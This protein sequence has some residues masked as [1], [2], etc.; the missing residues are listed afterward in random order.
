MW[1]STFKLSDISRRRI[2][3][4]VVVLGAAAGGGVPQ[5]NC[6]CP[7]CRTA[8]TDPEH[9]STQASI[10]ISAHDAHWYLINASPDLR[11]QLIPTPKLHP[12]AE[13]LRHSPIS[14]VIL[15][16]GEVDAIAGLLSML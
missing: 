7:V 13:Q 14:G 2:M 10:A 5:W 6:G 12:A 1:A 15:T 16:N 11:Q 8:R 4:R 3:L 9:Q